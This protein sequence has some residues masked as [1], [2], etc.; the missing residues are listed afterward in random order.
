MN[1]STSATDARIPLY[2]E[3]AERL[4]RGEYNLDVPIAPLDE[5]GRLG[6]ALRDLAIVLETRYR[7]LQ[8]LDEITSSI[9]AGL[10]LDEILDKV[11]ASFR[12]VIPYNRI[13]FSLLEEE[14]Q[15]VRARWARSD[16]PNVRLEVGYTAPLAGSSLEGIIASGEPRIINDLE[17]YLRQKPDSESTRLIVEEGIRS[18]LTCP[19]IAKGV[20]VGFIFFSSVEPNT[21]Q[22]VHVESFQ[23]IAGQLSIIVEKGRLVTELA[24]QK[25]AIEQQNVELRH[26]AELKNKLLGMAAHDLRNP[27]SYIHSACQFLLDPSVNLPEVH[28][29]T[30]LE[31][32]SNQAVHMLDLLNELLDVS[33]IEAGRLELKREPIALG[34]FLEEAVQRHSRMATPKGTRVVLEGAPGGQVTADRTRLRQVLDNLISNAVKYAPGGSTVRVR[35]ERERRQWRVMVSDEGP[36]ITPADRDG[37][38]QDFARLS[39]RPTGGERS[40]GLGLAITRRVVEAHRGQIGVDSEEGR[41]AT[42]WFTLPERPQ[43]D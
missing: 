14:G 40:T 4:K 2:I 24:E 33:Q 29:T 17:A 38:F 35:A 26:L 12:E 10:L 15:T 8:K 28:R 6:V 32:I 22:T 9:N 13:G 18:S 39:A 42:F 30:V 31:D 37:L 25:A 43:R 1:E 34:E 7:E 27:I 41:G 36:G 21:Y 16:R 5:I 20:P 23:R 19:L 3:L 11:Y